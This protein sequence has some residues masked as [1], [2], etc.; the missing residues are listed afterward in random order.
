MA[1]EKSTPMGR[2]YTD[3]LFY[4]NHM[5]DYYSLN[6]GECP[7][8]VSNSSVFNRDLYQLYSMLLVSNDMISV[9]LSFRYRF[10]CRSNVSF[11]A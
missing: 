5:N 7:D 6:V 11:L 8:P 3:A 4:F 1:Y 10:D 9:V 2:G